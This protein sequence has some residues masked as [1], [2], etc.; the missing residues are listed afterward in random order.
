VQDEALSQEDL[1]MQ[2]Q[3]EQLKQHWH[4]GPDNL[5]GVYGGGAEGI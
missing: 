1:T 5:F 2:Y 4:F 3:G